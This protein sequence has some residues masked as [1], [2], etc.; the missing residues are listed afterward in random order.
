MALVKG[1]SSATN[2]VQ[3]SAFPRLEA[4]WRAGKGCDVT[5][6]CK[7]N[8][9]IKAHSLVLCSVSDKLDEL[10]LLNADKM[11]NSLEVEAE[12]WEALLEVIYTGQFT[13][14]EDVACIVKMENMLSVA[15]S[16]G[17]TNIVEQC[18]NLITERAIEDDANDV[19]DCK[20]EIS[21]GNENVDSVEDFETKAN[22]V[23]MA[24]E[25]DKIVRKKKCIHCKDKCRS[26]KVKCCYCFRIVEN[27]I[28]HMDKFHPFTPSS[29]MFAYSCRFIGNDSASKDW[30]VFTKVVATQ[31]NVQGV[32]VKGFLFQCLRCDT[33]KP[34]LDEIMKHANT[35]HGISA[36]VCKVC[37]T[38]FLKKVFVKDHENFCKGEDLLKCDDC[39]KE[40]GGFHALWS[41]IAQHKHGRSLEGKGIKAVPIKS[42]N[43]VQSE[44]KVLEFS[45]T[46]EIEDAKVSAKLERQK[47]CMNCNEVCQNKWVKCVYCERIVF[48]STRHM[49]Q[50]HPFTPKNCVWA[51]YCKYSTSKG[52][53]NKVSHVCSKETMVGDSSSLKYVCQKCKVS[54]KT[55]NMIDKHLKIKHNIHS[56]FHCAVCDMGFNSSSQLDDHIHFCKGGD[57]STFSP[58]KKNSAVEEGF[59]SEVMNSSD[60]TDVMRARTG[61]TRN[62]RRSIK[63]PVRFRGT[64]NVFDQRE[65]DEIE[66]KDF[67]ENHTVHQRNSSKLHVLE[68][69]HA[70]VDLSTRQRKALCTSCGKNCKADLVHCLYCLKLTDKDSSHMETEHPFTLETSYWVYNCKQ[71]VAFKPQGEDV[72]ILLFRKE[73]PGYSQEIDYYF[74]CRLCDLKVDT[75]DEIASHIKSKHSVEPYICG[76]CGMGFATS[77]VH[78]DH[79]YFCKGG[80]PL[81]CNVCGSYF[82][83]HEKLM[84]HNKNAHK[85]GVEKE[86]GA[87]NTVTENSVVTA[88]SSSVPGHDHNLEN[89]MAT[90]VAASTDE[91]G[92]DS[93]LKRKVKEEKEEE[94]GNGVCSHCCRS[95]DAVTVRCLYCFKVV[96]NNI[97]H[98]E[99]GHPHSPSDSV[100]VYTCQLEKDEQYSQSMI[101]IKESIHKKPSAFRKSAGQGKMERFKCLQCDNNFTSMDIL[102]KH[103]VHQFRCLKCKLIFTNKDSV[104]RHVELM[105]NQTSY[106]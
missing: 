76:V 21:S 30:T 88:A 27:D 72:D 32:S 85:S 34:S 38:G 36:K 62:L 68:T 46:I 105:H 37:H 11:I 91:H 12:T 8:Q 65:S 35:D 87:I 28:S 95:C 50:V 18:Q 43:A 33:L 99:L 5:I 92:K 97:S 57:I 49:D 79:E 89:T 101:F 66:S 106:R 17:M 19:K 25:R 58:V 56:V 20:P 10:L 100:W 90:E 51:Y 4:M 70:S 41:H 103:V 22:D 102:L 29:S 7:N 64:V 75:L 23:E 44:K 31:D 84:H 63:K 98:K 61:G 9:A 82:A 16:L 83:G 86:V 26:K 3:H 71:V 73:S 96:D 48:N 77:S 67:V 1:G 47:V 81:K 78:G 54:Y 14:K 69:E 59:A 13:Y 80:R 93:G 39:G 55:L 42:E 104:K 15:Q 60:E 40:V 94:S 52:D 24:E 6:M 53:H 2:V 45:A 74:Q